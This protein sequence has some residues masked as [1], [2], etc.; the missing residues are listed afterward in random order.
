MT[1]WIN[2]NDE[3]D[4][5]QNKYDELDDGDTDTHGGLQGNAAMGDQSVHGLA[6]DIFQHQG[7]QVTDAGS[8]DQRDDV[9]AGEAGIVTNE[10]NEQ[11]AWFNVGVDDLTVDCDADLHGSP[12]GD[13]LAIDRRRYVSLHHAS[14]ASV[15]ST[16]SDWVLF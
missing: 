2:K 7:G 6:P 15:V 9:G 5:R 8:L 11:C 16:A 14:S 1:K 3:D 12:S 13:E 10:L 4:D